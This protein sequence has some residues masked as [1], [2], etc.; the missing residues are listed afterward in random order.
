MQVRA[1]DGAPRPR[2]GVTRVSLRGAPVTRG[3]APPTLP[4]PP[5]LQVAELDPPGFLLAVLQA[6]DPD[7]DRL[8]YDIIGEFYKFYIYP[9]GKIDS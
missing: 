4:A 7:Q 2:C 1:C 9:D 5:P 6:T 8:Y 3:G